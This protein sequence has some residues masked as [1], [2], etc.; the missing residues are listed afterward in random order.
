MLLFGRCLTFNVDDHHNRRLIVKVAV[1]ACSYGELSEN[2]KSIL[3]LLLHQFHVYLV[4]LSYQV[5]V[6]FRT[7]LLL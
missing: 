4:K 3:I 7:K 5:E 6:L 1:T 2:R